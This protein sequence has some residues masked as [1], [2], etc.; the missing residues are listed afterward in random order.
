MAHASSTERCKTALKKAKIAKLK[1]RQEW[2]KMDPEKKEEI[3][4][5]RAK[6]DPV[7]KQLLSMLW[8]YEHNQLNI[9][10]KKRFKETHK[11]CDIRNKTNKSI[12]ICV[13]YASHSYV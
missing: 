5:A 11:S 2:D 13:Q 4:A 8:D 6:P 9:Y 12:L 3:L 10:K 7:G 1:K